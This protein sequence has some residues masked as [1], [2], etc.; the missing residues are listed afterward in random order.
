MHVWPLLEIREALAD[1][2]RALCDAITYV[3]ALQAE[4]KGHL[5]PE[6]RAFLATL[7]MV[8]GMLSAAVPPEMAQAMAEE[9]VL[10]DRA[11]ARRAPAKE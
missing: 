4:T 11:E 1:A 7:A 9:Q 5:P 10:Y 3:G 6:A 2:D 8:R